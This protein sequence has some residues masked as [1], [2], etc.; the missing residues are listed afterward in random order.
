MANHI[1]RQIREA[2]AA[3]VTGLA[4]TGANVF[5]SR[6]QNLAA[7]DLP[8][9]RIYTEQEGVQDDDI[10]A[11]PY[12][13]HREITLRVEAVAKASANLDDTLDQIC[14]EVEQ[15]IGASQSSSTLGGLARLHCSLT[16]TQIQ[17]D[18]STDINAGIATMSWKV[19][20]LTM[21]NAP[22]V[23]VTN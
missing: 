11:V 21:S 2:F 22:N 20:A 13:Q 5:Q 6:I 12:L 23:A 14:L 16:G 3:Q 18:G 7:T 8:A 15:A 17:F 1:R 9:L 4:T 19:T 10:L